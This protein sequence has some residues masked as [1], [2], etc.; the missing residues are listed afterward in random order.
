VSTNST[1]LAN[2]RGIIQTYTE[3]TTVFLNI[4]QR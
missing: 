1:T 4:F 2:L 3:I